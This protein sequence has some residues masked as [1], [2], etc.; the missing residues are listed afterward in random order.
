M[1]HICY[2]PPQCG[3]L[4]I[5][6]VGCE[7][8]VGWLVSLLEEDYTEPL[9]LTSNDTVVGLD[10]YKGLRRRAASLASRVW[11][12]SVN[13]E[14]P[15]LKLSLFNHP[16]KR[17]CSLRTYDVASN[18]QPDLVLFLLLL[19]LRLAIKTHVPPVE[20][21]RGKAD[22]LT[23]TW[24]RSPFFIAPGGLKIKWSRRTV[25]SMVGW[26]RRLGLLAGID[27][28]MT[29]TQAISKHIDRSLVF[30]GEA[31]MSRSSVSRY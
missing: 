9:Y 20:E 6:E 22:S 12:L 24:G 30:I 21:I 15:P 7:V 14:R 26:R 31:S 19:A 1:V 16:R 28:A 8:T 2:Y 5:I 4:R 18:E 10:S 25:K 17:Q 13:A 23:I 27:V 3:R 29:T 11:S